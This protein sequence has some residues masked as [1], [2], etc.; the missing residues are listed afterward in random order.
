MDKF[1][2]IRTNCIYRLNK[3]CS[4]WTDNTQCHLLSCPIFS[5]IISK[6]EKNAIKKQVSDSVKFSVRDFDKDNTSAVDLIKKVRSNDLIHQKDLAPVKGAVM[7]EKQ[8]ERM[9]CIVCG[10][11]I[12]DDKYSTIRDPSNTLIYIHS[13]GKCKPRKDGI[14]RVR[15]EWLETHS[16]NEI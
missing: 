8:V 3:R 11:P 16:S 6:K 12:T 4:Y 14:P 2:E 9:I 5:R 1:K 13:K 15:K 10:E 7:V